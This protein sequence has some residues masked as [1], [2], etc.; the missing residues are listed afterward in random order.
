MP[1]AAERVRNR[2]VIRKLWEKFIGSRVNFVC[3]LDECRPE[4]V[5]C[6]RVEILCRKFAI[7]RELS[8]RA[9]IMLTVRGQAVRSKLKCTGSSINHEIQ[10]TQ[11]SLWFTTIPVSNTIHELC[12]R[13]VRLY[14]RR[15]IPDFGWIISNFLS[16]CAW[17][18]KQIPFFARIWHKKFSFQS[19]HCIVISPTYWK[20]RGLS[21]SHCHCFFLLPRFH[22]FCTRDVSRGRKWE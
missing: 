1:R 21:S 17:T 6:W 11:R 19:V 4:L 3:T 14:D 16:Q 7:T 10:S 15:V 5:Y 22:E 9:L 12:T 2:N 8:K 18:N 20:M 13:S